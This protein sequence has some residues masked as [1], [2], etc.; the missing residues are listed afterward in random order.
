MGSGFVD[1][2]PRLFGEFGGAS[3]ASESRSGK[4]TG[5]SDRGTR[6]TQAQKILLKLVILNVLGV[7]RRVLSGK[8][9]GACPRSGRST[10]TDGGA[11]ETGFGCTV[12]FSTSG[13]DRGDARS[14]I[15]TR[16]NRFWISRFGGFTSSRSGGCRV[17]TAPA[18]DSVDNRSPML[19][20]LSVAGAVVERFAQTTAPK[21]QAATT[22][23]WTRQSH[24][25]CV[26]QGAPLHWSWPADTAR[27]HSW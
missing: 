17:G 20:S 7:L 21:I 18:V 11:M 9:L 6:L 10:V 25:D 4:A 12:D 8:E 15:C 19:A 22:H 27:P 13:T 23:A 16:G 5:K 14:G 3:G 24:C 26:E 2:S 1:G